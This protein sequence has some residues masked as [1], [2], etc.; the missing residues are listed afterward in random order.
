[1]ASTKSPRTS[2][3]KNYALVVEFDKLKNVPYADVTF[4]GTLKQV[5][6]ELKRQEKTKH[7]TE[8]L[9]IWTRYA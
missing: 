1:M 4:F 5:E 9:S 8:E 2:G 7:H 3:L 6:K